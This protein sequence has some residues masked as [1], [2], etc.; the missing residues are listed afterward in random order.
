MHDDATT[1]EQ[2]FEVTSPDGTVIAVWVDG[3][4]PPIVLVHGSLQD[5]TI[6]RAFVEQLRGE[7]ATYALDRRGFGSSGDVAPYSIEREFEDVASVVDSVAARSNRPV[8][9]FGHSFGAC[10]AMGAARL[11]DQV[12]HLVLY[13]PSFGLAY[14]PGALDAVDEAVAGGDPEAAIRLVF[15]TVLGL[16]DAEVDAMRAGPDWELRLSVA[17]TVAREG[18]AEQSWVYEP[19]QFRDVSARTLLLA[20]SDSPVDLKKSTAAAAAAISGSTTLTMDGHEHIAH[21]TDPAMVADLVKGF[22][23]S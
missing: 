21:R 6:S 4:G 20:G 5:H 23:R 17:H 11:T 9:L 13:E 14:P 18:R 15:V 22:I 1:T 19:D 8:V 2:R 16:S 3:H 10:C 7:F 12:S